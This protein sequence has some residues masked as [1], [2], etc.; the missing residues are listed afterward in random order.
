MS[1]ESPINTIIYS[2]EKAIKSYRKFA[3]RNIQEIDATIT[4]DQAILLILIDKDPTLSQMEMADLL[5]KDYASI[6]RMIELMVRKNYI[7]RTINPKDRRRYFL[8]LS[9]KGIDSLKKLAPVILSNRI[10]A[11]K[12]LTILEQNQLNMLLLKVIQNCSK[13]E[14]SSQ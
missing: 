11:L 14:F 9:T 6:T 2:I 7:E 10:Q 12:G 13:E 3:Q 1:I 8:H 4:V 5:F